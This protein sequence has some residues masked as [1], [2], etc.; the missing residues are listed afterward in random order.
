M[1]TR[2]RL[3]LLAAGALAFAATLSGAPAH[4]V[5][6]GSLSV[7]G[8]L[9]VVPAESPGGATS[10]AVALPDGD[11][12]PVTGTFP[13]DA[14]TGA[15][16]TG[17]LEVPSDVLRTMSQRGESGAVAA[18]RLVDRRSLAL[19]VVGTPSV[20]EPRATA[21]AATV[22]TQYVA[23]LDNV[24]AL[25]QT[26]EQLLGHVSAVGGYWAGQSDGAMSVSVPAGVTHYD[27]AVSPTTCG[28][29]SN[30]ADFTAIVQ[31]AMS[32][33]PGINPYSGTDQLVVFVPPSCFG[34]STVG[35]GSIGSS[36]ASGGVLVA[37]SSDSIEG[38]YAHEAGH[39]YGFQHANARLSGSSLEYY[40]IYDVMGFAFGAPYNML[41]A[42]STPYRV[43][44]GITDPGEIQ[45]VDLGDGRSAVHATAT[46]APRGATT[47]LRSV[48]VKDPDTGENLYLDYRSGIGQDAS[49]VY[50]AQASLGSGG[51]T[52]RYAPGVTI[53]A[54]RRERERRPGP[55]R[56]GTHLAVR[57]RHLDERVPAAEGE[58]D[59][60]RPRGRECRRRLHAHVDPEL[61]PAADHGHAAGRAHAPGEAR[62]VD[63]GHDVRL[64]LVRGRGADQ[65]P[66]GAEA[67][68]HQGPEGLADLGARD[69]LEGRLPEGVA[70][71]EEVAQGDL[72]P[73]PRAVR[74]SIPAWTA[75]RSTTRP[76]WRRGGTRNAA[77]GPASCGPSRRPATS[78][79]ET[80]SAS[81]A[82]ATSRCTAASPRSA[83]AT[84][85]SVARRRAPRSAGEP[86]GAATPWAAR[87]TATRR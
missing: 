79:A 21:D 87:P 60:D 3:G 54:A 13:A 44:Q 78:S 72:T 84:P 18:L 52:L 70:D 37:E 55:R 66:V 62:H 27:T 4:A 11:L 65:A 14:R 26:D 5:P 43:F 61:L 22:H 46:I 42:L 86:T 57:G 75:T 49:S 28:L 2:T 63:R 33:F 32:K 71:V 59:R 45:I 81:S 38:V 9:L 56:V 77:C 82:R 74:G 47:G 19:R 15:T 48:R 51:T 1:G 67:G 83:A 10:Y 8:R 40:G 39:N 76:C 29:G 17:R 58:G 23:A 20:T 7:H 16:F 36:F 80:S 64:R 30:I 12:V 85:C 6:A 35:R 31:E 34:G 24:G 25:G 73:R 41:T 53:N 50:A 68:A 69:R